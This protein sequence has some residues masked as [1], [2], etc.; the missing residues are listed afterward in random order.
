M[1]QERRYK[2]EEHNMVSF[3]DRVSIA[4]SMGMDC[5]LSATTLITT[6]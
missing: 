1:L 4:E 2:G 5:W 3:I 6:S